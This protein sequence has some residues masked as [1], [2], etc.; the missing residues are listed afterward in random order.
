MPGMSAST[1]TA[2]DLSRLPAPTIVEQISYEDILQA[3]IDR[4]TVLLPS[5]DATVDSD[6][7]VK[8]L[9]VAAYREMLIRQQFNDRARQVMLAFARDSNLDQLGANFN[10][11]RLVLDPGDPQQGVDPVYEDDDA[12]RERIQLS[13]EGQSV[14]GPDTAYI[15]HARSAD[16]TIRDASA[17][18]P[19]PGQVLVTILSR[20]GNGAASP[21][22]LDAVSAVL[23]TVAGNQ[24]RPLTDQVIVASAEIVNYTIDAELTFFSGPDQALVL[25]TAQRNLDAWLAKSGKLGVDAVRAAILAALFV[26]G[27]QNVRLTS[28]A[29]DVVVNPTQSAHCAGAIV[30]MGGVDA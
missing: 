30:S 20:N 26:E 5:F 28:P 29:D 4:V 2:I 16:A 7:A 21:E 3:M 6:P 27:V 1:S 19:V 17:I 23:G 9:Q 11:E 18:S 22:Q 10:V 24:V 12:Y 8:V 13:P 14:A 25:A 15:F